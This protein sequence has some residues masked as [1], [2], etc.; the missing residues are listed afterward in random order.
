MSLRAGE[1]LTKQW[2]RSERF[3]HV[4]DR[5]FF[6]TREFTQEGPYLSKQDAEMESIL[7]I[8]QINNTSLNRPF[9]NIHSNK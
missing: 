2:F 9:K 5:W 7:Y 6:I 4:N 8:R 1:K 3:M